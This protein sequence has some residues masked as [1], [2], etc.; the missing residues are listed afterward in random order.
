MWLTELLKDQSIITGGSNEPN[1]KRA[2]IVGGVSDVTSYAVGD[3]LIIMQ[4]E[5]KL[6]NLVLSIYFT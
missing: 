1:L 5:L 6:K 2:K 4:G 3:Q